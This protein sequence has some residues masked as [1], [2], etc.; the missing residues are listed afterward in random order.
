VNDASHSLR[1]FIS[2]ARSDAS[3]FA[4]ELMAGLEAAGFDPFLDRH[5]ISP[6]EDWEARLKNLLREADTVV[7]VLSPA[8]VHSQ[9]CAWEIETAAQLSKRVIPV[10]AIDVAE[11]ETPA[12]L[13]RLNY[14]FFSRGHGFGAP[15]RDLATAL[16]TDLT[17]VREHT[18]LGGLGARWREHSASDELLL[19]GS[20]LGAAKTWLVGWTPGAPEPTPLHREFINASDTAQQARDSAERRQLEEISK[21]QAERELALQRYTQSNR[22]WTRIVVALFVVTLLFAAFL[23]R[24]NSRLITAQSQ[25]AD[26]DANLADLQVQVNEKQDALTRA[27]EALAAALTSRP[28]PAVAP[29]STASGNPAP[30]SVIRPPAPAPVAANRSVAQDLVNQAR[31]DLGWDIDVFFCQGEGAAQNQARATTVGDLLIEERNRQ[32]GSNPASRSALSFAVGRVRV[33]PLTEQVNQRAGY[34]IRA[35]VVRAEAS[36]ASQGEA[37]RR[38]ITA[39]GGPALTDDRSGTRTTYYLSVF[40]CGATDR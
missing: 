8:F 1:V 27:A 21:A 32:A 6:G 22:R 5:D 26:R 29:P 18:R 15:L 19:R 31:I 23:L 13:K 40:L 11:A 14:I 16:R 9:R 30:S 24:T 20:E 7:Y 33:R 17:W 2:Y 36:E 10:V 39:R 12:A 4:E 38:F 3:E 34:G 28:D 37:L 35:D 25:L